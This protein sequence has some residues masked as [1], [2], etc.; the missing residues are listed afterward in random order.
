[1]RDLPEKIDSKFRYVLLAATR[2]EQLMKGALP[3]PSNHETTKYTTVGMN[4]IADEAIE[5]DYG[6]G[7]EP[8][9]VAEDVELAAAA[10]AE[11]SDAEG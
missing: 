2:A 6:P 11:E 4:E 7:E 8:V 3:K 9:M 5:W 10:P 1:M